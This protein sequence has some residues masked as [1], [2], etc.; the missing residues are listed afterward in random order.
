MGG[1]GAAEVRHHRA[2]QCLGD[3]VGVADLQGVADRQVGGVQQGLPMVADGADA[4][5]W[6][7]RLFDDGGR[8]LGEGLADFL[9]QGGEQLQRPLGLA[10]TCGHELALQGF[11]IGEGVVRQDAGEPPVGVE[12]CHTGVHAIHTG[13]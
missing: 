10:L 5:R 2:A 12:G 7:A 13:A 6:Q 3:S 11:R 9:I 1:V 8:G 4:C